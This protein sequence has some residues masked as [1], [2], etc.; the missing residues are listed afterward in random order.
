MDAARRGGIAHI[1]AVSGLHI[2]I[3]YG[4]VYLLC[5][6]LGKYRFIPALVVA[7]CYCALCNFTVSSVRAVV[8]CG[9]LG[10]T[11]AFG[12]K[13]DFLD[14][15]SFAAIFTLLFSP[16]QWFA[17]S[18]RLSFGACL[19]LAL[20][21]G[22]FSR[23]FA[24]LKFPKFL[25]SYLSA[26]LS[27]QIFLLPVM[28][29][30]F[31]YVSVWGTLLNFLV[32]PALPPLFLILIACSVFA[33][34][35][36]PAAAFFLA[37][38]KGLLSMFLYLFSV[39]DPT[40]VLSGFA[41]GAGA[42][43]W[44]VGCL[45]LSERINLSLKAKGIAA[46]VL[47][48]VLTAVTIGENVV[49]FGCRIDV[50]SENGDT[51][52]FVCTRTERVLIIDGDVSLSDCEDFLMARGGGIDLV[53]VLTENEVAAINRAAF[54]GAKEIRARYETE[55]GLRESTVKFGESF[56]CGELK[57]IYESGEK[58][59]MLYENTLVEF[60]FEGNSALGADLFVSGAP[61]RLKYFLKNGIIKKQ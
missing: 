38:P 47:A 16:A 4:A 28:L 5:R 22:S 1:F 36:P 42:V 44:L 14:S 32:L 19:G 9:A 37:L 51:L 34:V 15:I 26:N 60:D 39:I 45:L 25:G 2:G 3:L 41:L 21:A 31:G 46:A 55:T 35:I 50:Y 30:S 61:C 52:A 57:F 8:M 48:C 56:S 43:V 11:R 40:L 53:V 24:K 20:F 58:L 54:L 59:A 12:E 7:G 23:L 29:D 33:L 13:Y 27:I 17:A 6:R 10:I 18:F 49:F